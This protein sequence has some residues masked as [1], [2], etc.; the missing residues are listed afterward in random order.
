MGPFILIVALAIYAVIGETIERQR[1][2][3][4]RQWNR[5]R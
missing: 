1:L 2:S 3:R 4:N 5:L